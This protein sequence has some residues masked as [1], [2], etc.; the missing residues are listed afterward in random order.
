[1]IRDEKVSNGEG[2]GGGE[3]NEDGEKIGKFWN[4]F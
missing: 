2:N 4:T 1:L 3:L